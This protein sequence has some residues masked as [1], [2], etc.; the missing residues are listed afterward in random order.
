MLADVAYGSKADKPSRAKIHLCPLWSKSGQT[1]AQLDCSLSANRVGGRDV[2][3]TSGE[4]VLRK[5]G[6]GREP[7]R[8]DPF[9]S[10]AKGF[11]AIR[12]VPVVD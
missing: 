9:S 7:A 1:R 11:I 12:M 4:G 3:G 2:P 6:L 10:R 8:R 5:C